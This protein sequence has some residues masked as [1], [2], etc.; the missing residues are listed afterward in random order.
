MTT[1]RELRIWAA[2]ESEQAAQDT[3]AELRKR[4]RTM[5]LVAFAYTDRDATLRV[6][7][8]RAADALGEAAQT[9]RAVSTIAAR[10]ADVASRED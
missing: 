2:L 6:A 7:A 4:E 5:R 9:V 3:D 10:A 1:E 8:E